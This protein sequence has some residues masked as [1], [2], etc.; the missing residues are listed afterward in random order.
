MFVRA[1]LAL[2]L[3]GSIASSASAQNRAADSARG[4]APLRDTDE[5][6]VYEV[7]PGDTL[8]E[9]AVR[10]EIPIEQLLASN[11]DLDPDHI[12]EGQPLRVDGGR[13]RIEHRVGRGESLSHVALRWHVRIDEIL[14]WNPG[15]RR[16]RVRQGRRLVIYTPRPTSE[17]LSIGHPSA[18]RLQHGRRLL[19][20]RGIVIRQPARAWGTDETVR[21][22]RAGFDAMLRA[23]ADAPRVEVHDLSLRHGGPMRGHRSHESGRD[24]DIAYY[25]HA[26]PRGVCR[27]GRIG[28]QNL[29]VARQWRLLH[30]WLERG[31]VEA[32]FMDHDLQAALYEHA[33]SEGVSRRDLSRWFQYPREPDNRYGVIRHHPLHADHFHVRFACHRSD[34]DC[35]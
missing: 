19:P 1:L 2:A 9:I 24:V 17:S 28:P 14:R 13:R 25:Q 21:F 15:L 31:H 34:P 33:R 23:D 18:G 5:G 4:S 12:R 35:R 29:D 10:L 16:D 3:V 30:H 6:L 26:C 20:H 11:P 32:I 22:I 7:A 8:S 27:F